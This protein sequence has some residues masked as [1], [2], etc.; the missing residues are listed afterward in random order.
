MMRIVFM[1]S[2]GAVV[3]VLSRMLD[4]FERLECQVVGVVSQPAKPSGRKAVLTD[5]AVAVFAKEKSIKLLQPLKA[6]SQD[7]LDELRSLQ[8]D[9][10]ITAAY[11]QIL[12]DEFLKIPTRATINIHPSLLP[13]YRGATP[14]AAALLDGQ[15]ETGVT[16]LFT[17]KALDAGNLILQEKF[18]IEE[19]ETN[20]VL[21]QRLFN[22]SCYMLEDALEKLKDPSFGGVAQDESKVTKCKKISKEDG[23][24]NWSLDT[25]TILNRFRAFHPWPGS[26]TFCQGKRLNIEAMTLGAQGLAQELK[27][28]KVLYSKQLKG[29]CVGSGDGYVI[30]RSLKRAGGKVLDAGAFWNGLREKSGVCFA[31]E[32]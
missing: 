10:I 26:F 24:I 4:G 28:S 6:R 7:F 20:G 9:V 21:T 11:G 18:E 29:L 1:G 30:I 19:N 23:L 32:E 25:D 17:V 16:I 22:A 3:P 14:I 31:D 13:L 8:P 12:S 2:P 15:T 5:P 27:P